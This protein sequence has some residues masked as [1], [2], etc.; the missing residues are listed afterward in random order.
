MGV[1]TLH[2][3]DTEDDDADNNN[4]KITTGETM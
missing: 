2:K 4:N 1:D 3:R